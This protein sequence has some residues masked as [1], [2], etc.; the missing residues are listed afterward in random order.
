MAATRGTPVTVSETTIGTDEV[1]VSEHESERGLC[2]L[3]VE[4]G[5]ERWRVRLHYDGAIEPVDDP[6][7]SLPGWVGRVVRAHDVVSE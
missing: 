6:R 5:G 7:T 1:M 3:V 4:R 2:K